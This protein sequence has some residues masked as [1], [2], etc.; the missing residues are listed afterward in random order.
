[1]AY[2]EEDV[3]VPPFL[4]DAT[5]PAVVNDNGTLF[6]CIASS[7]AGDAGS[8]AAWMNGNRG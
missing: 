3:L 2:A 7:L 1:M 6:R 8:D 4:S 5:G